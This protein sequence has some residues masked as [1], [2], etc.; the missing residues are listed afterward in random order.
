MSGIYYF[1]GR[2]RNDE[3]EALGLEENEDSEESDN[4]EKREAQNLNKR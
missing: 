1:E 4:A 3:L 2:N